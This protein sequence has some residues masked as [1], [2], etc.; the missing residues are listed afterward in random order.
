MVVHTYNFTKMGG[1]SRKI[2][3][4]AALGKESENPL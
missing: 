1:L 3:V 2:T 4:Q